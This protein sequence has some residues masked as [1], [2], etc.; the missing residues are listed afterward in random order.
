M[1]PLGL[2]GKPRQCAPGSSGTQTASQEA[3]SPDA[4]GLPVHPYIKGPVLPTLP[5][6][7]LASRLTTLCLRPLAGAHLL[8]ARGAP[9]REPGQRK[10]LRPPLACGCG[11]G[12]VDGPGGHRGGAPSA[13]VR[14]G[15]GEV[16][17]TEQFTDR[18]QVPYTGSG[19]SRVR[20]E[21]LLDRGTRREDAAHAWGWGPPDSPWGCLAGREQ[22][23]PANPQCR[24]RGERTAPSPSGFPRTTDRKVLSGAV[25]AGL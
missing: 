20:R 10:H 13:G 15:S 22:E 9:G 17:R 12:H 1:G 2:E 23:P 4:G 8:P 3:L 7:E 6:P 16:E 5:G 11:D 19:P 25:P 14:P 21:G 18:V 24:L